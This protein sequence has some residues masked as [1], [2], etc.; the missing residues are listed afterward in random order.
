MSRKNSAA[1]KMCLVF[2]NATGSTGA[3][4]GRPVVGF[5]REKLGPV[6]KWSNGAK[7]L[8]NHPSLDLTRRRNVAVQRESGVLRVL[9]RWQ[10]EERRRGA[11]GRQMAGFRRGNFDTV[12]KWS[13]GAK[14]L[15]NQPSRNLP[16][17]GKVDVRRQKGGFRVGRMIAPE[18]RALLVRCHNRAGFSRVEQW[19]RS[20][21]EA[22]QELKVRRVAAG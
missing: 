12:G 16:R 20:E 4:Q 1:R 13:N 7:P 11:Q 19:A 9:G 14:P 5:W 10:F 17:R 3:A 21:V 18:G 15:E 6:G 8:E 22:T 2:L